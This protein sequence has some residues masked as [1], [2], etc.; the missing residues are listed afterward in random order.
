MSSIKLKT[1]EVHTFAS[2]I[3]LENF[4]EGGKPCH[5]FKQY[6]VESVYMHHPK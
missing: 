2:Y 5:F 3:F 4:M 6:T 1:S